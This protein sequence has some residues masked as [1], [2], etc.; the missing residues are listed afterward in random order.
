MTDD[1]SFAVL[2]ERLRMG[3]DDAVQEVFQRYVGRLLN[4]NARPDR[5]PFGP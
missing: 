1:D 3:E 5:W 2:I 4:L